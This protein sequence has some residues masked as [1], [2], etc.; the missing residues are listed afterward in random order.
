MA[1]MTFLLMPIPWVGF[2]KEGMPRVLVIPTSPV[3][4]P[5]V[6]RLKILKFVLG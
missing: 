3:Y 6:Q 4:T 2:S 1:I 5:R